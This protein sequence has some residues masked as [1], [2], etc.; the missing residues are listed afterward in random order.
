MEI[1]QDGNTFTGTLELP[2][3]PSDISDGVIEGTE[4]SFKVAISRQGRSFEMIYTGKIEGDTMSGTA[5]TPR[6][7]SEWSAKRAET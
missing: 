1:V 5:T 7:D 6:G 4:I 2:F 3:G